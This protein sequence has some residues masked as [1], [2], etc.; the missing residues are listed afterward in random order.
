MVLMSTTLP[1]EPL[2]SMRTSL[3]PSIG[4]NDPTNRFFDDLLPDGRE[5]SGGDN[6]R[7]MFAALDLTLIG[8]LEGGSND[9]D[10]AW[11]RHLQLQIHVVGDGHELHVAW[12]S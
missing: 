4:S 1:M 3:V 2:G 9:D 10:P 11:T 5:L 7:G 8:T 6:C 12:T